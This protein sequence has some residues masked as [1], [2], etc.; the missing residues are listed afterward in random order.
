MKIAYIYIYI[1]PSF[2]S[3][4]AIVVIETISARN[5]RWPGYFELNNSLLINENLK[6]AINKTVA[7]TVK[8]N[9]YCNRNSL[10]VIVKRHIR[11]TR[12]QFASNKKLKPYE[13]K[14]HK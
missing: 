1:K 2:E 8:L 13:K 4:H 3:D 14:T 6:A 5:N 7:E 9:E 12:I 11:K 10:W